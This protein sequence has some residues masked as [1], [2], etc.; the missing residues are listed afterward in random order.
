[1]DGQH[2]IGEIQKKIE[3]QKKTNAQHSLN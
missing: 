1:L 2:G 3:M